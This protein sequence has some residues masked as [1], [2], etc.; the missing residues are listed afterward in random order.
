ME[1]RPHEKREEERKRFVSEVDQGL[2]IWGLKKNRP[3]R[4]NNPSRLKRN[5]ARV[6]CRAVVKQGDK[7]RSIS[8]ML[9]EAEGV[10][11]EGDDELIANRKGM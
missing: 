4:Q 3:W 5:H 1:V 11:E 2:V 6:R 8:G 7:G 9:G 10:G